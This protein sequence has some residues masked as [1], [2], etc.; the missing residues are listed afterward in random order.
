MRDGAMLYRAA[1]ML[2]D[3][4][5]FNRN[6]YFFREVHAKSVGLFSECY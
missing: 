3:V 6:V 1:L 5:K 4:R 2:L